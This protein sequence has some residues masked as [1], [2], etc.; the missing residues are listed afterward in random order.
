MIDFEKTII[1][2]CGGK[3]CIYSSEH[4]RIEIK[5][6]DEIVK[7][8]FQIKGANLTFTKIISYSDL[9]EERL[10]ALIKYTLNDFINSLKEYISEELFK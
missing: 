4:F 9:N 8:E 3:D 6:R 7:I 1:Q 10:E 5:C 2:I